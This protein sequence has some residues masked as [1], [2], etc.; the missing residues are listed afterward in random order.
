VPAT[1][2]NAQA[3]N[4]PWERQPGESPQAYEAFKTYRDQGSNRTT[5][6]VAQELAKSRSLISRWS[7]NNHW[8]RRVAQYERDQDRRT[9]DQLYAD[10]DGYTNRQTTIAGA[11]SGKVAEWVKEKLKSEDLDVNQAMKLLD[12]ANK[13]ERQARQDRLGEHMRRLGGGTTTG[14]DGFDVDNMSDEELRDLARQI[15]D[16]A[17]RMLGDPRTAIDDD[18]PDDEDD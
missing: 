1:Q 11:I 6:A 4:E 12:V 18:E 9:L 13:I 15:R 3:D 8:V 17:D 10:W 7:A 2:R 16:E 14:D 5:R